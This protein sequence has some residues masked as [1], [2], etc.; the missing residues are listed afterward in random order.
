MSYLSTN[1]ADDQTGARGFGLV[2]M[3]DIREGAFVIDYRGE[4]GLKLQQ[5]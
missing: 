2:A 3:E 1:G 5:E 4:V